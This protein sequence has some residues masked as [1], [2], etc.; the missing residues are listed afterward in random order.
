MNE[1]IEL[2]ETMVDMH[3]AR[4]SWGAFYKGKRIRTFSGKVTWNTLGAAKNAIRFAIGT[5][6]ARSSGYRNSSEACKDFEEKGILT[7]KQLG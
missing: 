4:G 7:Y 1:V 6:A 5:S 2:F 3:G